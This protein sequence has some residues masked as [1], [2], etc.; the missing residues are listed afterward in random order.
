MPVNGFGESLIVVI[1]VVMSLRR[2]FAKGLPFFI[3]TVLRSCQLPAAYL[4]GKPH[5]KLLCCFPA[6]LLA[7]HA[8]AAC[9]LPSF[10]EAWCCIELQL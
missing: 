4:S 10:L 2:S 7:T 8:L 5:I 1:D 3:Q 6:V 9:L